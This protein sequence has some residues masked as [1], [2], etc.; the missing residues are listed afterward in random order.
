MWHDSMVLPEARRAVSCDQNNV[1][2][3]GGQEYLQHSNDDAGRTI[4]LATWYKT[5]HGGTLG[6]FTSLN[7]NDV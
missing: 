7:F 3:S 2:V 6:R 1:I 5:G 4:T